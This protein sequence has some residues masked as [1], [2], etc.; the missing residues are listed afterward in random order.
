M[1]EDDEIQFLDSNEGETST[2]APPTAPSST[3]AISMQLDPHEPVEPLGSEVLSTEAADL[4]DEEFFDSHNEQ[5][6]TQA[7]TTVAEE[8]DGS[9][10]RDTDDEVSTRTSTDSR[11]SFFSAVQGNM[12]EETTTHSP[13]TIHVE[14]SIAA[15]E[16][17]TSPAP[18][19]TRVTNGCLNW[20]LGMYRQLHTA[21]SRPTPT[22]PQVPATVAEDE[23]SVE[24]TTL[25]PTTVRE[26]FS[27]APTEMT[28]S[29]APIPAT[30]KIVPVTVGTTAV[31]EDEEMH[32]FDSNDG[33]D[34]G[35]CDADY[36]D[37]L[38]YKDL[39]T[40]TQVPTAL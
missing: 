25:T 17:T 40:T 20:L 9:E 38:E 27:T 22:T 8:P 28:T 32:F 37:A 23:M 6:T 2:A 26:D 3:D 19:T 7:H 11:T 13:T 33:S 12:S 1:S 4:D 16:T 30:S 29:H 21:C 39:G 31:S 36:H 35:D 14:V 5:T 18:T 34:D 10:F 15:A 24:T